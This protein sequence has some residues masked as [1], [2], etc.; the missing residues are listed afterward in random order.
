M[1]AVT[2]AFSYTGQYI[3]R[4]L[5]QSGAQVL[6]L[7]R[8]PQREHAFG[9]QLHSVPFNFDRPQDLADSLEG[10][11][12]LYN[13]YWIRFNYGG[14]TFDQ[15]VENSRI[16]FAAAAQAGVRRIVHVSVS[17]ASPHSELAYFRGKAAVEEL[18]RNS[19]LGYAIIK[20]TLIFGQED[21][22]LNNITYLLRRLPI[23]GLPGDGSYRLQPVSAQE[24]AELCVW[25]AG[26]SQDLERDAAG[27]DI[28]TFRQLVSML[29]QH[30]GS[31]T[32][33]VSLPAG[34][35]LEFARL[36]GWL[37]G[38]VTLTSQ[39]LRGLMAE[40]LV[41]MEAPYGKT[42]LAEWLAENGQELGRSYVSELKRNFARR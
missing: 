17:N 8:D 33:L 20:P 4:R 19:G 13:T 2:G 12:T 34:L 22:L 38:D 28:L 39:E 10:V 40:L 1:E 32:R 24:T 7:T 35:A 25:A 5:L 18:V 11:S 15:A 23:F 42:R 37:L 26:Q 27:P 36:L 16:L 14:S 3:A 9:S 29:K 21:L 31:Q 30:S 41:S 6:N